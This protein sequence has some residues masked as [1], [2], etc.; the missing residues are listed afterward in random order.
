MNP[1]L[2]FVGLLHGNL[3]KK[4]QVKR[5]VDYLAAHTPESGVLLDIGCGSGQI[6][7]LLMQRKPQLQIHGI[8]IFVR[9]QVEIPV[10]EFDGLQLP[11]ADKSFD[12]V[13]LIDVLHH[14]DDQPQLIREAARVARQIVLV[15]DHNAQTSMD[16]RILAFMDWV[17]NRSY[18][19]QLPYKY[20]STQQ[21]RSLFSDAGCMKVQSFPI[22]RL[23][24]APFSF[25][26]ERHLQVLY[27][28]SST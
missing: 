28:A 16:R 7:R 23:Y 10:L 15:K 22:Q 8:D 14:A 19:V 4:R 17:G 12:G 24:P 9:S 11:F 3:V 13:L 21:W 25:V 27:C 26:F 18:G 5:I 6:A 20:L 2:S 1:L